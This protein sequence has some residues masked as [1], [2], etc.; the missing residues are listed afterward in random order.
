MNRSQLFHRFL[1]V[2][3]VALIAGG[4]LATLWWSQ[5]SKPTTPADWFWQLAALDSE[6]LVAEEA[7]GHGDYAEVAARIDKARERCAA[8]KRTVRTDYAAWAEEQ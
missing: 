5:E 4:F 8:V 3:A 2:V 7:L 1:Q 6:L